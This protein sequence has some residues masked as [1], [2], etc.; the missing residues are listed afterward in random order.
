MNAASRRIVITGFMCAGKTTVAAALA[1]RLDCAMIDL[2]A[3][4]T[5]IEHRTPQQIIETD[6]EARFREIEVRALR[7]TLE[8]TDAYV[9]ALGGGAWTIERNRALVIE[10]DCLVVWLDA[11]FALCWRRIEATKDTRPLARDHDQTRRLYDE[12]RALYALAAL[13]IEIDERN[14]DPNETATRIII[15]IERKSGK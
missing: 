1:S 7:D 6:G 14:A 12:R 13:R 4:V 2:D 3:R 15:T 10:H 9:I 5:E 8:N 11:P